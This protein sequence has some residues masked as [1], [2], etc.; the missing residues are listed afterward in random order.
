MS[1]GQGFAKVRLRVVS[2]GQKYIYKEKSPET[3]FRIVIFGSLS[4]DIFGGI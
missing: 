2:V 3:I 4:I 1:K